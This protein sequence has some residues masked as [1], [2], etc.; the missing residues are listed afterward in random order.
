VRLG[1]A[2]REVADHPV[3]AETERQLAEYFRGERK[4]FTLKLNPAG[5]AFQREVWQPC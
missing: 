5:T 3:L 1:P 2:Q 4:T